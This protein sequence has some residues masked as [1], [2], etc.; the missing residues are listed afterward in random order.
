V[1]S[2]AELLSGKL[3]HRAVEAL[4][5]H[6]GQNDKC[7]HAGVTM[8]HLRAFVAPD[9]DWTDYF[10]IHSSSNLGK[11]ILRTITHSPNC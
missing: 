11:N 2:G 1:I 7:L 10:R 5:L 9:I 3:E 8:P 6:V 4:R